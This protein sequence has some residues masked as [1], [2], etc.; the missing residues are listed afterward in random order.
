[1]H[2]SEKLHTSGIIIDW[3]GQC[4]SSNWPYQKGKGAPENLNGELTEPI[5]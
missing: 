1:M 5:I 3:S 4:K 2:L